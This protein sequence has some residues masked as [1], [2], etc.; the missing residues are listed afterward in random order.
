MTQ[1]P[2]EAAANASVRASLPLKAMRPAEK[3]HRGIRREAPAGEDHPDYF[4]HLTEVA[5]RLQAAGM[6]D[7]DIAAG[8]LHDVIEDCDYERDSLTAAIG[9]AEVADPVEWVSEPDADHAS[10][11]ARNSGYRERL[12]CAP[13]AARALS[14]ADKT[15][16]SEDMLRLVRKG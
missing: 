8:F 4:L 11:Q 3:A 7:E 6:P 10:W 2:D 15:A 12:A 9:N 13:G 1:L 5:W 16:N 14:C